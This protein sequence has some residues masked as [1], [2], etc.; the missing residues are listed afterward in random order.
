MATYTFR[1]ADFGMQPLTALNPRMV[2]TPDQPAFSG[3]AVLVTRRVEAVIN[4]DGTGSVE[5]VPSIST[6]PNVRYS[7]RIEWRDPNA[8]GDDR[9]YRGMDLMSGII[10]PL[11]GGPITDTDGVALSQFWVGP[12]DPANPALPLGIE[13]D[14]GMWWLDTTTGNLNEWI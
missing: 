11:G 6:T 7:M 9:G 5:L 8:F 4:P 13:P 14:I 2:F 1:L 10:A 12:P 3:D